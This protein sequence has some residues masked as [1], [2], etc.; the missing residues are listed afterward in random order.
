MHYKHCQPSLKKLKSFLNTYKICSTNAIL[1]KVYEN[2]PQNHLTNRT[3]LKITTHKKFMSK[4]RNILNQSSC[5]IETA[6]RNIQKR[7][8]Y[9]FIEQILIIILHFLFC[10]PYFHSS[11]LFKSGSLF[12]TLSF[13][14]SLIMYY[15]HHHDNTFISLSQ[16]HQFSILSHFA[17][18]TL[19]TLNHT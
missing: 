7:I 12:N 4:T 18:M 13:T 3:F 17:F 14:H 6:N 11:L 2:A 9:R 8:Q 1:F 16:K 15:T 5:S 19:P 10:F